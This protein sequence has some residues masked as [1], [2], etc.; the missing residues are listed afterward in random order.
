MKNT[1]ISVEETTSASFNNVPVL[2]LV[3]N[4]Y[5]P[6]VKI[7][8]QDYGKEKTEIKDDETSISTTHS[9]GGRLVCRMKIKTNTWSM[10]IVLGSSYHMCNRKV[11]W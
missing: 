3:I 6:L 4:C 2:F 8:T 7:I 5:Q 9:S 1:Q 11:S 10:W